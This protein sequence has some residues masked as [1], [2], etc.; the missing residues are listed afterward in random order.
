MAERRGG[1]R[2]GFGRGYGRGRRD[3]GC[4]GRDEVEKWLPVTKL[5]R[6]V[7]EGK[8]TSLEQIYLHFVPTRAGQL[9]QFKAFVVVG[10]T[11]GHVDLGVKCAK[12]VP[13]AIRGA[14]VLAKLSV[15][16]IR[17]GHW[18]NMIGEPHT[19]PCKIPGK[20]SWEL[21]EGNLECLM[22]TYIFLT[23]DF[24]MDTHFSKSPFQGYTDLRA[25]PSKAIL[26]DNT[27]KDES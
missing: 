14:I 23:S 12:E 7:K 16:H 9:T 20:Y 11:D 8:I 10:D 13:T 3:R 24:W 2:D 4:V 21:R 27:E 26:L 18:G 6:L 15:I 22:K 17:R 25:K 5:G 1:D 19:V